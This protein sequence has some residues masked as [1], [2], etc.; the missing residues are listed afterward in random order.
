MPK[1][2]ALTVTDLVVRFGGV[3]ALAGVSFTVPRGKVCGLIG[4][5]GAG[6][7][8]LFDCVSRLTRPKSGRIELAGR[9]LLALPAHRVAELGVARTFQHLG[10]VPSLSVRENVMLGAQGAG[11]GFLPAALRLPGVR[12]RE[13][14]LRARADAVLD[15]LALAGIAAHPAAGLPYG[16]LK[17]IELARA[18]AAEPDLLMLDEPASGLS[19]EEVDELAGVIEDVRADM[20]VL[21]VEHHMGM[22]MRL[23]DT[24][25]VLDFGRVV[26]TGT[27]A[28]VREDPAVLAAYLGTP[29]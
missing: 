5:N 23:S 24:V 11:A 2:A 13:R 7:T 22:V 1:D 3:T 27:P 15:R 28:E 8:T 19:H 21:L 12:S 16:T 29:A 14:R 20:T 6:K 10:L 18:L 4:P 17:R 25:V 26:A 9:D